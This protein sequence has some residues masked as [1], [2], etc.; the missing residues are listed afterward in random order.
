VVAVRS[1]AAMAESKVNKSASM[2]VEGK[3][4]KSASQITTE[5]TAACAMVKILK[6]TLNGL[7]IDGAK[8]DGA[9]TGKIVINWEDIFMCCF[10]TG[11]VNGSTTR[12]H[13]THTRI[14]LT[15]DFQEAAFPTSRWTPNVNLDGKLNVGMKLPSIVIKVLHGKA[16]DQDPEVREAIE[17]WKLIPNGKFVPRTNSLAGYGAKYMGNPTARVANY[18]MSWLAPTIHNNLD[19]GLTKGTDHAVVKTGLWFEQL[20]HRVRHFS[21]KATTTEK[22]PTD[23]EHCSGPGDCGR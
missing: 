1:S 15:L 9:F 8:S 6:T 10:E 18:I 3:V 5:N 7:V 23:E 21:W 19:E 22:C 4:N 17:T 11:T 13:A 14:N 2:L 20:T 16:V 12:V